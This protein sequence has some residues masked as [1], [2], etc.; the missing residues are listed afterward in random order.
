MRFVKWYISSAAILVIVVIMFTA[1][2]LWRQSLYEAPSV[3]SVSRGAPETLFH[4]VAP[5]E[6]RQEDALSEELN[7]LGYLSG[8]VKA[9]AAQGITIYEPERA[10]EG[11]NLY[12]SGHAP[13][14]YLM[15]M[16]G[17]VLHRWRYPLD[18]LWP[19]GEFAPKYFR[20]AHVFKN[21]DLLA[22]FE[23]VGII[24]LDKDSKLLWS[25]KNRA[26]HDLS[27]AEDGAIYVLTQKV[28]PVF[29]F[30][31]YGT[32]VDDF[33]TELAPDGNLVR[34]VSLLECFRDSR[35][36]AYLK[37]AKRAG[38]VL[39]TNALK[40]LDGRH[41]ERSPAF[42]RG[43]FLVSVR[44]LDVVAVVDMDAKEVVWAL[45]GMWFRQHESTLL[46]NGNLLLFDNRGNGKKSKVVEVDPRTQ[47]VVWAYGL[48]EDEPLYSTTCGAA[49]R[50]PNGNTLIT[51]SNGGRAF[52]VTADKQIVWEYMS[53]HR[54]GDSDELIATLLDLSRLPATFSPEW[55]TGE[56][57]AALSRDEDL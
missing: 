54:A 43:N 17:T 32:V 9:P 19:D 5:A 15:A 50:L 4:K 24:K 44:E 20:R 42:R 57:R 29:W 49:A 37:R 41:A 12:T 56:T 52:E 28:H 40:F 11:L 23:P 45:S 14:A 13:E 21:G 39:H 3:E 33:I 47:E 18:Q 51:E 27:V 34:E 2:A 7:T 35:Y 46:D 53:P 22:I 31:D 8:Y 25:N 30:T 38:D 55:L 16:D 26:H 6:G 48:A 1:G 10:F 36:G